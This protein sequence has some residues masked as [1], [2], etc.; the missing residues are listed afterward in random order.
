MGFFQQANCM[1]PY[2]AAVT[3]LTRPIGCIDLLLDILR[4]VGSSGIFLSLDDFDIVAEGRVIVCFSLHRRL[5]FFLPLRESMT[6]EFAG[7]FV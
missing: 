5:Y 7:G 2:P 1:R 3:C 4:I 6:T